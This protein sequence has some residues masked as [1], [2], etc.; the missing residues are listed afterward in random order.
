[1]ARILLVDDDRNIRLLYSTILEKEG[2][3]VSQAPDG[4]TA[5][6]ML[7]SNGFDLVVSDLQMLKLGGIDVL[8]AAKAKDPQI[9]VLIFTGKGSIRTAV[10]AIKLGAFEYLTKPVD[11]EAF[12]IKVR[13]AL[14]Q[15]EMQL[16]LQEQQKEIDE[17]HAMIE[18][19][20]DLAEQVQESLVPPS[21]ENDRFSIGVGYCP[22]IGVG[23]D[24]ADIYFDQSGRLYLTLIDVTGH[25]ITAALLVN[26]VCSEVRNLVREGL[27]PKSILQMVNDFFVDSFSSTGMFLTM[28]SARLD[29]NKGELIYSG[30][31]HPAA[32]FWRNADRK[33]KKLD[34]Q[35]VIIGFESSED[36]NYLENQ[37]P[38]VHG[39][40]IILYTD[41]II[42]AENRKQQPLGLKGFLRITGKH[43]KKPAV[44]AVASII[45]DVQNYA[46]GATK[47]DIYLIIAEVK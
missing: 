15:R 46:D 11:N 5:L 41:G 20:L 14:A 4:E 21:V 40:K 43:I 23:G 36:K 12:R 30:S 47:D 7:Q 25:G 38:F 17:H 24:F 44:K 39:D 35:N 33:F 3:S 6:S 8:K 26:R 32:L 10:Q 1:M 34:S 45:N 16:R 37:I 13:N 2:Y 29:F 27:P 28:M 22:T 9:Q 19:D 18:R 42:E 31:A